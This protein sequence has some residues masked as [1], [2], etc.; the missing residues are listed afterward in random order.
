MFR[1]LGA[2]CAR[3][4][5]LQFRHP[6]IDRGLEHHQDTGRIAGDQRIGDFRLWRLDRRHVRRPRRP[7]A[8]AQHHDRVV[9]LLHLSFRLHSEFRAI[10]GRARVPRFWLRRRVGGR[11]RADGR[12]GPRRRSRQGGGHCAERLGVGLG[13]GR[14]SGHHHLPAHAPGSRM[15]RVVLRRH[16]ACAAGVLHSQQSPRA[17]DLQSGS[18]E[19]GAT[20]SVRHLR[21]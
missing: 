14:D 20:Q 6:R 9:R 3:C 21:P 18:R 17:R 2:R 16:S 4:A 5:D 11:V 12:S 10:A 8:Y 13:R 19:G 1:R 7:S 15:A